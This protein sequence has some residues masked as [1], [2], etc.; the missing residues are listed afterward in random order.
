[1]QGGSEDNPYSAMFEPLW[2]ML[3]HFI[4]DYWLWIA[5]AIVALCVWEQARRRY[6]F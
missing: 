4:A 6:H 1:M 5:A 3:V 2:D